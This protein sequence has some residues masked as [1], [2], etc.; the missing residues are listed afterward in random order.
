MLR[1]KATAP[2]ADGRLRGAKRIRMTSSRARK[3]D[4]AVSV[5]QV[6]IKW[7]ETTRN[8]SLRSLRLNHIATLRTE[9]S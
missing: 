4:E 9:G 5:A 7:L 3:Q 8:A 2:L 6:V 1:R